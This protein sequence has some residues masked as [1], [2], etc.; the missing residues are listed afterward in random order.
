MVKVIYPSLRLAANG[1]VA[2]LENVNQGFKVYSLPNLD[3]RFSQES[4]ENVVNVVLSSSGTSVGVH[5]TADELLVVTASQRHSYKL[6]ISRDRIR[7]LTLSDAGDK[8]AILSINEAENSASNPK[9][10]GALE[11]WSLPPGERPLASIQLP[12]FDSAV[13]SA[14]GAFSIFAV[15]STTSVGNNQFMGVYKSVGTDGNL[16]P[17][18]TE[19][20]SSPTRS[21]VAL[22][23]DWVWAVQKDAIAGWHNDAPPVTLPG[24][25]REHLIFS[26]TGSHLLA[27]R[28]EES[29]GVTSTKMLFRLFELSSLKQVKQ[30]T[31]VIEDDANAHFVLSDSLALLELR[32]TREGE[33]KRQELSW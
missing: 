24:T 20:E 29:M 25:L 23:N 14:N 19:P 9:D 31:H 12:L 2:L 11:I 33:I 7:G 3:L 28:G 15:R 10:N 27:Y 18:W 4:V 21:A 8:V 32:A 5:T 26:P 6:P 17:L 1:S 22:Y 16:S 30:V 13:V